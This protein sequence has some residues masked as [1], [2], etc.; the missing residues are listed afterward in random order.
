MYSYSLSTSPR[1]CQTTGIYHRRKQH[2]HLLPLWK[3]HLSTE[4]PKGFI[5]PGEELN[6]SFMGRKI[7]SNS[8]LQYLIFFSYLCSYE[9]EG[10]PRTRPLPPPRDVIN[11]DNAVKSIPP[12]TSFP[13]VEPSAPGLPVAPVESV[14]LPP[15]LHCFNYHFYMKFLFSDVVVLR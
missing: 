6:C 3:F 15:T 7:H 2:L 11:H 12:M 10:G 5:F 8:H 14:F 9:S 1:S 4:P 13:K